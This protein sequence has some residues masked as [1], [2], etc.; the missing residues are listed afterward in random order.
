MTLVKAILLLL[1]YLD[2]CVCGSFD[3]RKH[4]LSGFLVQRYRAQKLPPTPGRPSAGQ[5]PAASSSTSASCPTWATVHFT[6]PPTFWFLSVELRSH[7]DDI[8]FLLTKCCWWTFSS[9]VEMGPVAA[10]THHR[11]SRYS[12]SSPPSSFSS[13]SQFV[14]SL[15]PPIKEPKGKQRRR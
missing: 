2:V 14:H 15:S 12:L 4:F 1:S 8:L 6:P 3:P 9:L 11:L 13:W 5:D 10:D 7:W